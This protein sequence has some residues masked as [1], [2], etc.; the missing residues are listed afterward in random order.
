[1]HKQVFRSICLGGLAATG[2]LLWQ[3]QPASAAD[4]VTTINIVSGPKFAPSDVTISA[5][6]TIKWVSTGGAPHRLVGDTEKDAFKTIEKFKSPE[7]PTEKF[8][9]PGV[10]NY[11][12]SIHPSTMRGTITVK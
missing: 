8:E 2:L 11:H 5:G 1:M 10:I 3:Q 7:T 9:T 12:C 4:D 6:Q